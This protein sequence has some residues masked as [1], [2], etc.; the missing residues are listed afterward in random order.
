MQID[1]DTIKKWL[2]EWVEQNLVRFLAVFGKIQTKEIT[3][4]DIHSH[5]ETCPFGNLAVM[6]D[7]QPADIS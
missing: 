5:C 4:Q 2:K 6:L 7:L 1:R 3:V